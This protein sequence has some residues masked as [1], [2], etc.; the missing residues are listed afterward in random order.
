MNREQEIDD[1]VE[2]YRREHKRDTER[3]PSSE[4]NASLLQIKRLVGE[5]AE[6]LRIFRAFRQRTSATPTS[7]RV[8]SC[9]LSLARQTKLT[10][11]R[12]RQLRC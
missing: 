8:R 7:T 9:T 2:L 6:T 10:L 3:A 5:T 4:I 1:L 11:Q 12:P